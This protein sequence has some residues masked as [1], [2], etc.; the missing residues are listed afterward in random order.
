M[1]DK[2]R[3]L[4]HEIY[5]NDPD[6]FHQVFGSSCCKE[7]IFTMLASPSDLAASAL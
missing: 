4:V 3:V 6:Y 1:R 2:R 7:M 5:Q